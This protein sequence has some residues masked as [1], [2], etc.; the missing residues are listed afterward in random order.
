MSF[1]KTYSRDFERLSRRLLSQQLN[2]PEDSINLTSASKDGGL[3]GISSFSIGTIFG[4]GIEY[5]FAFEAKLR[6]QQYSAGIDLFAKAMIV[7][8]NAGH[9][10][11]VLVT[12][13]L[14]TD[15]CVAEVAG[16]RI[17]TGLK[18]IFIDG[19]RVWRWVQ[20][21]IEELQ[22]EGYHREFLDGLI[23]IDEDGL[24]RDYGKAEYVV[25]IGKVGRGYAR[26]DFKGAHANSDQLIGC[27]E[28]SVGGAPPPMLDLA[29]VERKRVF[30][31]LARNI[32]SMGGLHVLWGEPGV[33]KSVLVRHIGQERAASGWIVNFIDLRKITSARDL[34]L[35]TLVPLLG[36]DLSKVL[37]EIDQEEIGD[38]IRSLMGA[39]L[40]HADLTA[41][42]KVLARSH[43]GHLARSDLDHTVLL[44]VM[45]RVVER[46]AS[47]AHDCPNHMLIL[48]EGTYAPPEVMDFLA[49]LLSVL[50]AGGVRILME[51]R[52][53]DTELGRDA[54]WQAFTQAINAFSK[55]QHT[56][57]S[58]EYE[59]AI[60]HVEHL[61]PGIG[62][63]R[64]EVILRR[65]GTT[66][67]FIECAVQ[68][69]ILNDA[70]HVNAG[71]YATIEKLELFFEGITPENAFALVKRQVEYW[72]RTQGVLLLAAA[73]LNGTV[74][75][76]AAEALSSIETFDE[77]L[78]G[79]T[80]TKLFEV[81]HSVDKIIA[82][83]GLVIDAL[84]AYAQ[85]NRFA[86]QRVANTLLDVIEQIEPD[87][88]RRAA[89]SATLNE[90]AG[91][92]EAALNQARATG[93]AFV[94]QHQLDQADRYL[95]M[96]DR[97]CAKLDT[98]LSSRRRE[99]LLDLLE[100]RDQRYL[101]GATLSEGAL[102]RARIIWADTGST[103]RREEPR[104][105]EH[106]LRAGYILWRAEH[107]RENFTEAER[108]GV[109]LM[110]V[111][112]EGSESTEVAGTAL[113]ALGITLKALGRP[114][115][116]RNAFA[117]AM[118]KIPNSLGLQ[119]QF[120]SNEAALSLADAPSD[121]LRH[122][123]TILAM[124]EGRGALFLPYLHAQVD[125]AMALFLLR[126]EAALTQA[127]T[128]EFIASSNG[129]AAQSAR[130]F[131][132]IGCL[133]WGSGDVSTAHKY[134]R[135]A[136]LDAER[137][138]S[139]RF[140]WRM[141]TNLAATS[142]E[143]GLVDE[144][145][146]NASSAARRIL[147]AR[148]NHLPDEGMLRKARWYHALVQCGSILWQSGRKAEV[149]TWL[150]D[151]SADTFLEHVGILVDRGSA[152]ELQEFAGSLH[153]GRIM[154]TG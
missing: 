59:D 46:R 53:Y 54:N 31:S 88:Q 137:S 5:K 116:S 45:S 7:A 145:V 36:I 41:V 65:V 76:V 140:L 114:E 61:L 23:C 142:F 35:K 87:L 10:G 68:Y 37:S 104:S 120:H 48:E 74:P 60:A 28:T 151:E 122:Y 73:L 110:D 57:R 127:R 9:H 153:S 126:D 75:R 58:F 98:G 30:E 20:P 143:L 19:P 34:F 6:S 82:K 134:F 63:D 112:P 3:D 55:S 33:G 11:L 25:D 93:I 13:R 136:T 22:N 79:A 1:A 15:Q 148:R 8:F 69:L 44:M 113:S 103:Q 131:N 78:D 14:F 129:V 124:T 91:Q 32:R 105:L 12:N 107:T 152:N 17:R 102:G 21:R 50:A 109:A 16:F 67:F 72:G 101:L 123:D 71:N 38:L 26:V 147:S 144:A 133:T 85:E 51:A 27:V 89:L 149:K 29:G 90:A 100:L 40:P 117:R 66:P 4:D 97:L 56:L 24:L 96:A 125:R 99:T 62:P 130:A 81:A 77:F 106:R 47:R 92:V 52:F 150:S 94:Q 146:G 119:V 111:V 39:D 83:H 86:A 49:K 95:S 138:F 64:A 141:R 108:L 80:E 70:V 121:A 154:V 43:D 18:F 132:I 139:D 135:C 118:I 128:A 84:E 2:L 115:E 42:S